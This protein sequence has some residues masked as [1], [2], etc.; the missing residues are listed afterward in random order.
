MQKGIKGKM[1][2]FY[3]KTFWPRSNWNFKRIRKKIKEDSIIIKTGER[4]VRVN[5]LN[6]INIVKS[7]ILDSTMFD[8]QTLRSSFEKA[9]HPLEENKAFF[10]LAAKLIN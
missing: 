4:R 5:H 9:I 10:I 8:G 6:Y 2:L 3:L 7:Y 1:S